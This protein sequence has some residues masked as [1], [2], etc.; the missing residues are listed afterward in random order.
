MRQYVERFIVFAKSFRRSR[1]IR[2]LLLVFCVNIVLGGLYSYFEGIPFYLGLYWITD[3]IT[4]TGT[5]LVAPTNPVSWYITTLIMWI[6]LGV[7]LVFVENVYIRI[8]KKERTNLIN[9]ENHILLLGWS[10][11]MRHFLDHL[12]GK[13]GVHHDYVLL[14]DLESRPYNL[15]EIVKFIRGNPLEE[16]TLNKARVSKAKMAIVVMEDDSDAIMA[17][18]T[19]QS[20]NKEIRLCVNILYSEN[21]KHLKRIG[22]QEIVCDEEL[23][24]NALINSFYHTNG[25]SQ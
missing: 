7:T 6:G 9:F 17:S 12:S 18:M 4:N 11:K 5:G 3:Y 22:V 1:T 2:I 23:T 16:Y 20:L 10:Q 13:L 15:P 8:M 21:I 14:A 19:I 25:N 24:G